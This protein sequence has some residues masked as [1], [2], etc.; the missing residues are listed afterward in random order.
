M[1]GYLLLFFTGIHS[2]FIHKNNIY[3]SGEDERSIIHNDIDNKTLAIIH[4]NYKKYNLLKQLRSHSIHELT[5]LQ[6]IHN[7]DFL[8][9]LHFN[10]ITVQNLSRGL[11]L[12][13]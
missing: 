13:W 4:E 8:P 10:T 7:S 6:M 2:V 5:K 9:D 1:I 3:S 11:D 12:D